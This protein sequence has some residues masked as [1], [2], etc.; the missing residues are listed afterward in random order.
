MIYW[1]IIGFLFLALVLISCHASA[2]KDSRSK[3]KEDKNS[4]DK[5]KSKHGKK[6]DKKQS[7]VK[8]ITDNNNNDDY[9]T[10]QGF[11][12]L[13]P[14]T[15]MSMRRNLT[16]VTSSNNSTNHS[17]SNLLSDN[18]SEETIT[19]ESMGQHQKT[20]NTNNSTDGEEG[21]CH[22]DVDLL[23]LLDSS[24]SVRYSNW[25]IVIKFVKDLCNQFS[26][27][28]TRVAFI[29]FASEPEISVPLT[30]FNTTEARDEAID[31]IFY[32][33]GGTRTDIALKKAQEVFPVGEPRNQVIMLLTD[34]PTNKLEISKDR[35]VEGKD[36]VAAP[37][38]RLKE[39]GIALFC[40]GIEPDSE[41]PEE[42]ETMRE[43]MLT[44]ASE[45]TNKHV[46]M[47]DGYHELQ[48]KVQTVS[49]AA[50][51][52]NGAWSHWSEFSP[53]SVTCSYGTRVRLRTCTEPVPANNGADCTGPRVEDEECYMGPC[54]VGQSAPSIV[55]TT[56]FPTTRHHTATSSS[57]Y[58]NASIIP[59]LPPASNTQKVMV[60]TPAY[61]SPTNSTLLTSIS[62]TNATNF[63]STP[64]NITN[65][66][67]IVS[68]TNQNP[69]SPSVANQ[70]SLLNQATSNQNLSLPATASHNSKQPV[71]FPPADD[72]KP[73]T[74]SSKTEARLT[75]SNKTS[76]DS[77]ASNNQPT[78][79]S[80]ANVTSNKS[81]PS[82]FVDSKNNLL[83]TLTVEKVLHPSLRANMTNND[84]KKVSGAS[85]RSPTESSEGSCSEASLL[86][87]PLNDTQFT[88]S[89]VYSHDTDDDYVKR[90][91][92]PPNA[93]L[94][95]EINGGGWCAEHKY[96]TQDDKDQFIQIDLGKQMS[97]D[98]VATQG[99]HLLENW[100]K[101]YNLRYSDDGKSWQYYSKNPLNGN[102][103][104]NS[105][106]RSVISPP[107]TGRYFQ[108]NP[109]EWNQGVEPD[110]HDICMRI[111]LFKCKE[112]PSSEAATSPTV[113]RSFIQPRPH[114]RSINN[115]R[116][117]VIREQAWW[118]HYPEEKAKLTLLNVNK[119]VGPSE[120]RIRRQDEDVL[121]VF[122]GHKK[123]H[124][125]IFSKIRKIAHNIMKK[126]RAKSK[127]Q[128]MK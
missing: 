83:P 87:L 72:N 86:K 70:G 50:C 120:A 94:N 65:T 36:L 113:K 75:T 27:N 106:Q 104:Q 51:V 2:T 7:S 21:K 126:I 14:E 19:T 54:K 102:N 116:G 10:N 52:V 38:E 37:A 115:K 100:V 30:Q 42:I 12:I 110:K 91:Y 48:R 15:H 43:E 47:S 41:T 20:N 127:K 40:I 11:P 31:N 39:T 53:C 89:S 117:V 108:L 118:T 68:S 88:A 60:T 23:F 122:P 107:I 69:S 73:T 103:D 55:Y 78:M 24:E 90:E 64:Q 92:A 44:I 67:S 112:T 124:K 35:F 66:S 25:K 63:Q 96:S 77:L 56:P 101:K 61:Y 16:A 80:L 32:K 111:A 3:D 125:R 81:T 82:G 123:G 121:T 9:E 26:L 85:T 17:T 128:R 97:V 57:Y 4:D 6:E 76:T 119:I 28:T 59:T 13:Y 5:K 99:S 8:K 84:A 34:G 93:R 114:H 49:Q 95:N 79:N 18:T 71:E 105:I 46:F 33:T 58:S 29:R 22:K 62:F 74:S 98:G 1:K 45:P 109:I